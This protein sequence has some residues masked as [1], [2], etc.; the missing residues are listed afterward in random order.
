MK[1]NILEPLLFEISKPGRAND[2]LPALDVPEAP[3]PA[4]HVRDELPLPE[5]S[6]IDVIR[7]FTRLS[8]LN[9]SIDTNFYP[10]GSCTMKYNP[11]V[12][13]VTARLP[14]FAWLHPYQDESTVQGALQ[15]MYELQHILAEIA[16][17]PAVTLQPAAGA[18]GELTG[19]LII[20]AY[21]VHNGDTHRKYVLVPDSAHGTNPATAAMCGYE[22]IEI[23][24]DERGNMDPDAI[25]EALSDEVAGLM[26]TNPS[27]LGLFEEHILEITAMVHEAG[28]LVYCDGANMNA[29]LGVAKPGEL[30]C[31]VLHY[32]L[33]KTFSTPH[34]GGGPGAGATAVSETLAPFLPIPIVAQNDEGYY[35]DYAR[36]HSIGHVRAFYGNF[37]NMV[38]GYTY[39]RQQGRDGLAS[40]SRN[41][42]LNA[43]YLLARL[44]EAYDLPY[45]RYCMHEVVLS[46][47]RQAKQGARTLDIAKRL[48]DFGFHAPTIYFPLIVEE[49]LMIEPTE[50]ESKE[51]LDAFVGAM[52]QIA[53]E[54]AETPEV[55]REAPHNTPVSRLDEVT[56]A[57]HPNLRWNGGDAGAGE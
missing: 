10:L 11:K 33:H 8:Q 40:V 38:R 49:A 50:T 53:R 41:A 19:M 20:R 51:T 28:G 21:H 23:P 17:L 29:L 26:L 56:A 37:G 2:Y 1:D 34:G 18:Q 13:E 47:K 35:L 30:G 54:A 27:T 9:F 42:V 14:G 31:D 39:I 46:G 3:L 5:V 24:S 57:R 6:E 16:G 36:P 15:L 22:V 43:N 55:V 4:G 25:Q 44:R 7:H 48:L 32:N 45:D 52:L 12:N